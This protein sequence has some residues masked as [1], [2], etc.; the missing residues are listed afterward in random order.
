MLA[1][2]FAGRD[3]TKGACL[4]VL[5]KESSRPEGAVFLGGPSA[6]GV[7]GTHGPRGEA[8]RCELFV[9]LAISR[10]AKESH[11]GRYLCFC[12]LGEGR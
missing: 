1:V 3:L 9:S 11:A 10:F 2:P 12:L 8:G 7:A 4:L 6:R 5:A